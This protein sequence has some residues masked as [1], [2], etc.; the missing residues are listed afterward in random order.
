MRDDQTG[1]HHPW[2]RRVPVGG[3]PVHRAR[4]ELASAPAMS[5]RRF[6][7]CVWVVTLAGVVAGYSLSPWHLLFFAVPVKPK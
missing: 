1:R 4:G 6:A 2:T 5:A 7:V 3:V